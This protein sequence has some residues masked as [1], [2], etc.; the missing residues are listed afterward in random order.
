MLCRD[1]SKS[2]KLQ[3]ELEEQKKNFETLFQDASDAIFLIKDYKY[4]DVNT[5]AL[6]LFNVK[7][8]EDFLAQEPGSKSP[9]VQE[10]GE[11]SKIKIKR[12]LDLCLEKGNI[13]FYWTA[14]SLKKK[15]FT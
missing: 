1:I 8:K 2:K 11:N 6:I 9:T 13:K 10:D 4:I 12:L 15:S 5:A 7:S 3:V 14:H